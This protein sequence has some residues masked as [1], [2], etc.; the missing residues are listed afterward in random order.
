MIGPV[1]L[2]VLLVAG[3]GF[4]G[5][6]A[7]A[8]AGTLPVEAQVRHAL[9][10]WATPLMLEVLEVVNLAGDWRVILPGSLL[11]FAIFPQARARWWVWLTLII[12]TPLAESA[13]K[14]LVARPRPED[15][16]LG[17]PSGHVTA[18]AAFFSAL[19]YMAGALPS[20]RA[21]LAVRTGAAL[22]VVMVALARVLL[23]AHWPTDALGGAALGLALAS[24]A[25]LAAQAPAG[26]ER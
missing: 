25:A 3:S 8:L 24:A 16:S 13:A 4:A 2:T 9:L 22:I 1:P 18:A 15:L 5:L 10:G 23:R 17:F 21:R 19:C 12:A 20:R 6:T 7:A 26:E 14:Y 11:L